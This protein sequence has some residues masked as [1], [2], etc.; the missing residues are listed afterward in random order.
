MKKVMV[1]MSNEMMKAIEAER[2]AR[3]LETIPE[4]IRSVL[5]E[6][7]KMREDNIK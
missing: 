2:K 4:T 1:S 5:G 7:F 3:K 6:Y